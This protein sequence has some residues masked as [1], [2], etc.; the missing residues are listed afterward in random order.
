M[1]VLRLIQRSAALLAVLCL[2]TSKDALGAAR[3]VT[4]G[5]VISLVHE[6]SGHKLYSGKISWGSGSM[7]QAVTAQPAADGSPALWLVRPSAV[8]QPSAFDPLL[9]DVAPLP[10]V[11]AGSP[12]KCG[13]HVMFEHVGSQ[14][15][16]RAGDSE[17]PLSSNYAVGASGGSE[18][19]DSRFVVECGE[20]GDIWRTGAAVKL[21]N[22]M[23]DAHL[24]ASK[25]HS[26]SYSNCGRGCPIAGHLEVSVVRGRPSS[27]SWQQPADAWSA[28]PQLL[29]HAEG[30]TDE[31]EGHDEL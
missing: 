18:A 19:Q 7:G 30:E 20:G 24:Q 9:P 11:G 22:V 17:A 27:W 28:Q 14:A 13:S 16:L 3:A 4:F 23:L 15:L 10:S 12:V 29:F 2:S 5:S 21:R 26:F 31:N 1:M 8:P 6:G 25:Q